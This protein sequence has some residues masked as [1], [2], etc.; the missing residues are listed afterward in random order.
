MPQ[1]VKGG[2]YIY[3]WTRIHPDGRIRVPEEAFSEY[4]FSVDAVIILTSGSKTSGGFSIIS[5]ERIES[6]T[7]GQPILSLIRDPEDSQ[8]LL[9]PG[10]QVVTS[11]DRIIS[12][13]KLDDGKYFRLSVELIDTLGLEIGL[14]RQTILLSSLLSI[15][16][17]K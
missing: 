1:L 4:Q 3:G 15:L 12:T 14:L 5:P 10:S 11:G 8:S 13:I 9:S 6:T 16:I 7:I 2:K 17:A